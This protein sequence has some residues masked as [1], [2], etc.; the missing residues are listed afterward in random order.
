M[1]GL[2][3]TRLRVGPI[4]TNCYLLALDGR[5]DCLVIDPGDEPERIVQAKGGRKLDAILFTHGHFDHIGGAKALCEPGTRVYIHALDAPMLHDSR[6][7]AGWMLMGETT[8]GPDA[9]DYVAEGDRMTCAGLT[10]TV[11]HTPGHTPGSVC[12]LLEDEEGSLLFS[13]DTV[14]AMGIGRTDLPGGSSAQMRESLEKLKPYLQTC[15]VL[16]GHG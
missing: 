11:L 13:G 16:G 3:I 9:T 15:H 12:Y 1:Q 4:Q 14:M 8:E 7:N 10:F 2:Q 5:D 6:K